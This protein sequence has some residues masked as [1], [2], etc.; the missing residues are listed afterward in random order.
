MVIHI[1]SL[2]NFLVSKKIYL[3]SDKNQDTIIKMGLLFSRMMQVFDSFK[4]ESARILMLGLDAAGE[5]HLL[6]F[7]ITSYGLRHGWGFVSL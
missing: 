3:T 6:R 2:G 5:S 1:K 4:G 7:I